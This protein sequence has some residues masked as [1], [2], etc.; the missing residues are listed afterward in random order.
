MINQ[1]M[2]VASHLFFQV[3]LPLR[4]PTNMNP[5]RCLNRIHSLFSNRQTSHTSGGVTGGMGGLIC[6]LIWGIFR[7][8]GGG[9]IIKSYFCFGRN[10]YNGYINPYYWVDDHPLLYANNGSLDPGKEFNIYLW[11]QFLQCV[12]FFFLLCTWNFLVQECPVATLYKHMGYLR[13][14]LKRSCTYSY[15]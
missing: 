8:K 14:L 12:W 11:W 3:V 9:K 15:G 13:R 2:G 1:Y 5:W 7:G 6:P 10:P 4:R